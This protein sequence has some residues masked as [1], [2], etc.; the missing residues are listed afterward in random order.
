VLISF[1]KWLESIEEDLRNIIWKLMAM[2]R[3]KWSIITGAVMA[4]TRL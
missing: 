2:D 1:I 3:D 4:G